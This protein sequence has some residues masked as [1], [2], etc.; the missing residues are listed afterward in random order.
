MRIFSV[1]SG[2]KGSRTAQEYAIRFAYMISE[3]AKKRAK[4]ISFWKTYGLAATEEAY[5]VK[6]RT[7]FL[8]QHKLRAGDGKLE[9]L[10]CGSRAP[11]RQRQ[12]RYDWR[13]VDELKRLRLLYPNLGEKKLYPLL[14]EFCTPLHLACPKPATIGRIVKDKGGMRT[15]P[16]R[17][18]GKGKILPW[19]RRK[20]VRK[21]KDLHV[22]YPGH[23]V[24]L[25]TI[26]RFVHGLRKYV[27]TCE[28]VN[29]R[30]TF[31]WGT[32]SHAS[33]AAEEFFGMWQRV[34]PY[35]TT[36][37]LTDNGSEWKKVFAERLLELQIT[38]YHT[39]PRTPKMNAHIE[40]FNRTIQEEFIDYHNALLLDLP[41]FNE[42]LM[43][44]L[45]FYNTK[46]VHHAFNNKLSPVQYL[47]QYESLSAE[48]KTTCG[49]TRDC[50]FFAL[51]AYSA[52]SMT[53]EATIKK[54]RKPRASAKG[55]SASGGKKA[56]TTADASAATHAPRVKKIETV[57]RLRIKVRAY[58]HGILDK[59]VKQIIDTAA[60]YNAEVVGP[61]PLPIDIKK[62]TVNRAAFIDKD[63]REQFEM[64]IHKRM[65]DILNP[66][67]KVIEALTNID[68]PSGV[69]I[70]VKMM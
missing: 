55:G 32:S 54:A 41:R 14:L 9:I 47:L 45:L 50:V 38:H 10:N 43:D 1:N 56:V 28:D 24:A 27:I 33:K 34:F 15:A 29:A 51:S 68:L 65:I 22:A 6:R 30:F 62:Y 69:S 13:I 5:G 52:G 8:W 39:Y 3:E 23:V 31:A 48:C 19:K 40:R 12:R 25:D 64:R 7:L 21:P 11:K 16:L 36:F 17:T 2:V 67:P 18:T 26:E 4:I 61:V 46:R 70:D 20:V 44:W 42:K 60:R 49:H 63:S 53:A 57:H 37:V 59:S 66:A 35:P 58:E